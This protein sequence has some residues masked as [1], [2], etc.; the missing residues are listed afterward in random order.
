[1]EF[2]LSQ[3][4]FSQ[5]GS[6]FWD[7]FTI[8]LKN[9][10]SFSELANLRQIPNEQQHE[11]EFSHPGNTGLTVKTFDYSIIAS[12][13]IA[14]RLKARQIGKVGHTRFRLRYI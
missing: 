3:S 11:T 13:A 10:L 8:S 5:L 12:N 4:K 1:V 9:H 7:V 2:Y 6:T 14:V